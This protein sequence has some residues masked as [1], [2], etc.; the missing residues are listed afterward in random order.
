MNGQI[1]RKIDRWHQNAMDLCDRALAVRRKRQ[2]DRAL[3]LFRDALSLERK[4]AEVVA[5]EY[6]FEPTRSVL[7]RSA[8]ALALECGEP[9][10]A[11]RLIATALIGDPPDEIADEL[12]DLLEQVNFDRHLKLRGLALSPDQLQMSIEG[13]AT[14]YGIAQSDEFVDRVQTTERLI[15]RTVERRLKRPFRET[16]RAL[17]EITRGV[18]LYLSV[19]RAASF[20]VTFRIGL[21][22]KQTAL[23]GMEDIVS[24]PQ[25]IIDDVLEGLESFKEKDEKRLKKI[26][27]D[28]TYRR[29]FVGLAERLAPDGVQVK[30][31]GLTVLRDGTER[32]VALVRRQPERATDRPSEKTTRATLI[33][34]LLWAS[35]TSPRKRIK[36]IDQEGVS[37]SLIVPA[38]MMADV[39]KPLWEDMV[40]VRGTR[41]G[42]V[43]YLE[44]H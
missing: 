38:G 39:V 36:I 16:G 20:A 43:V 21:P 3:Q 14:G 4:A 32:R 35:A 44:A 17:K 34:K 2:H 42:G 29:N 10:E 9:R 1:A 8:A 28:E 12:R 27:P 31:V 33:G 18:E 19:P 23:P 6:T 5:S 37:H 30:V 26:I 22:E 7:H 13:K 15:I 41:K 11:E 40:K 25:R 24:E